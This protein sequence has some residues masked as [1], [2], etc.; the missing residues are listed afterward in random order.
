M[1]KITATDVS[2]E[3]RRD[4]LTGVVGRILKMTFIPSDEIARVIGEIDNL[5]TE[6]EVNELF[7]WMMRQLGINA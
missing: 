5:V 2:P 6:Q 4:L 7:E 1:L 3:E